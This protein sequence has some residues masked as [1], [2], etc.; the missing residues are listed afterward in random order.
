MKEQQTF[1]KNSTNLQNKDEVE[2]II[3]GE[4]QNIQLSEEIIKEDK[5]IML[6]S[7]K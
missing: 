6:K 1:R 4:M 5:T 2:A 3:Q 7:S